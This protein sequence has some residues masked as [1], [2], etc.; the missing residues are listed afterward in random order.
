LPD[1]AFREDVRALGA[2]VEVQHAVAGDLA[3]PN[4]PMAR[5]VVAGQTKQAV[6]IRLNHGEPP[7][8]SEGGVLDG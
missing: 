2:D 3:F 4:A 8:S 5:P 7:F 1:E 6:E